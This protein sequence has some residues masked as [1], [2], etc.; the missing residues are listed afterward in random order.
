[1]KVT[2]IQKWG[3]SY[4]IRIPKET[5]DSLKLKMGQSVTL[6]ES[7][8]GKT[9]SLTPSKR[10]SSLKEMVSAVTPKNKHTETDWG[11]PVGNELW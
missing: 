5:I 9:L 2:T 6:V 8:D 1:M 10:D 11:A 4:A 7:K 3:N